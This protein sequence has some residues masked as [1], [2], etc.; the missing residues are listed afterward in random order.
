M[1]FLNN[2]E[3]LNGTFLIPIA[4]THI[5]KSSNTTKINFLLKFN[6]FL[7]NGSAIEV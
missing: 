3:L 2:A 7:I 4:N 5:R 6:I 1:F